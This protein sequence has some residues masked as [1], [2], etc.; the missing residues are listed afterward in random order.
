MILNCTDSTPSGEVNMSETTK[1]SR[2]EI[3]TLFRPLFDQVK[4]LMNLRRQLINEISSFESPV[5]PK[6]RKPTRRKKRV[7]GKRKMNL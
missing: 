5:T 7:A 1:L 3:K 4:I 2:Q 6:A